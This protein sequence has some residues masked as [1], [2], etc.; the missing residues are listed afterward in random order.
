[1]GPRALMA[2]PPPRRRAASEAGADPCLRRAEGDAIDRG[3]LAGRPARERGEQDRPSLL[4]GQFRELDAEPA[5]LVGIL[6]CLLGVDVRRRGEELAEEIGIEGHRVA[7]AHR[8]DRE[9]AGDREEPGGDRGPPRVVGRRMTPRALERDLGDVVGER[10]I[11]GHGD[12]QPEDPTLEPPDEHH[13]RVPLLEPDRGEE[14]LIGQ[15][16]EMPHH[17][18]VRTGHA[19][20]IARGAIRRAR[21][22]VTPVHNSRTSTRS[23]R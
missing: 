16:I 13:G 8:V 14:R 1:M 12:G 23:P 9:V 19:Q 4:D 3:D 7:H 5:E 10:R 11:A 17:T 22:F 21:S 6:G 15:P 18:M 20:W 2:P